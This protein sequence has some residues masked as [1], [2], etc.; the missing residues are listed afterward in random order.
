M[1]VDPLTNL[2]PGISADVAQSAAQP[3]PAQ[4]LAALR[5]AYR[6]AYDAHQAAGPEAFSG[7]LDAWCSAW[8][9]LRQAEQAA[10]L[11]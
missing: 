10:D 9:A 1:N 4:R 11:P 7:T 2:L 3:D 8:Q 6:Q 5:R